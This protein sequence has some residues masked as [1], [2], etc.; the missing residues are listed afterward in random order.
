MFRK[1][2]I[3]ILINGLID[4]PK[5][6]RDEIISEYQ[7]HFDIELANGKTEQAIINELGNPYSII[8]RYLGNTS[9]TYTK[10]NQSYETKDYNYVIVENS[11]PNNERTNFNSEYNNYNA[12]PINTNKKEKSIFLII[13]L[14]IGL[15]I[16]SPGLFGGI[17]AIIAT[18]FAGIIGS[19]ALTFGSIFLLFGKLFN[20]GHLRDIMGPA[21]DQIPFISTILF[22]IG[23]I[24]LT[25]LS[26]IIVSQL[27]KFSW[28]L[29]KRFFKWLKTHL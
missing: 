8:D 17:I 13:I 18:L 14:L 15:L 5:E 24:S 19:L 22:L 21:L 12:G 27:F 23:N 29:I 7:E 4:L 16:V 6:K 25:I 9:D 11:Q 26:I 20:N 2:F 10:T 1:E 28:K 3:N